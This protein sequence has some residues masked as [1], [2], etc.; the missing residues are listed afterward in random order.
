MSADDKTIP[1]LEAYLPDGGAEV[2]VGD[3]HDSVA[4]FIDLPDGPHFI[5]LSFT[6]AVNLSRALLGAIEQIAD[7]Q[8]TQRIAALMQAHQEEAF[9]R[10]IRELDNWPEGNR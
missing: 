1:Q 9:Q 4:V 7:H 2:A 6:E 10:F 8:E 5:E 3:S